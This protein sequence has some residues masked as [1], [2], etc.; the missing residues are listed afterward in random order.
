MGTRDTV[1]VVLA[2]G[3]VAV[4]LSY[5]PAILLL[6]SAE[7]VAARDEKLD[8]ERFQYWVQIIN[9]I[10]GSLAGYIA[11]RHGGDGNG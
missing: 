6:V 7:D 2:L 1:A 3:L 9:V 10:V 11:G 8:A 5:S 4:L